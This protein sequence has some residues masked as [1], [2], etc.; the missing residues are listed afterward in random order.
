[1]IHNDIRWYTN[2]VN[3]WVG[4]L[5]LN[6][7][8]SQEKNIAFPLFIE[9]KQKLFIFINKLCGSLLA[10]LLVHDSSANSNKNPKN[11]SIPRYSNYRNFEPT[12]YNL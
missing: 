1:M 2:L 6:D 10:H 4:D 9:K 12:I 5:A 11:Q 8:E 7:I 3:E